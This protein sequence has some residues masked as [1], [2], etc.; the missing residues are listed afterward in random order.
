MIV[1]PDLVDAFAAARTLGDRHPPALD[2][3]ALTDFINEG[4]FA[5]HIRRMRAL[6]AERQA[7][8]V[9]AATHELSGFLEVSS[10]EAGMHL[11]GWLPEGVDDVEASRRAAAHGVGA[12]PLSMYSLRPLPRRGLLLG[13]TAVGVQEIREGVQRLAQA[14][15]TLKPGR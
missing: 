2:Q 6:Y 14:L 13:Y 5:R 15:H 4:H 10:A 1:P 3:A 7:T 12:P 8:L 9:E 11:V